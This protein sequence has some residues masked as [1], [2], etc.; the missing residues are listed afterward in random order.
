MKNHYRQAALIKAERKR[1]EKKDD[2]LNHLLNLHSHT[3]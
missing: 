2:A 1:E 3:I